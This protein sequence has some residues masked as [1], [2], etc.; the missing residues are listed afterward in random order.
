MPEQDIAKGAASGDSRSD[1]RITRVE[2]LGREARLL[3][4]ER[5][6]GGE[7]G[8]AGGQYVIINTGVTLPGGKLAKRAYS[9]L[10]SDAV[11]RRGEIAVKRIARGPGS[12]VLHEIAEGAELPFSGPW[13]KFRL[14]PGFSGRM[15]VIVTDT[16]ITAALGIVRSTAFAQDT[17]PAKVLW[18]VESPSYFVSESFVRGCIPPRCHATTVADFLPVG[19][20]ERPALACALV[21]AHLSAE[22]YDIVFCAGDG[23]VIY[24]LRDRLVSLGIPEDRVRLESFFNNP[25]K[26]SP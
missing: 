11:Q 7:L 18:L 8:F 3:E 15:L 17:N 9:L 19:H 6:D 21:E 2:S 14:E 24:P 13:G 5:R 12:G 10:S 22:T 1:L 26:K 25:L 4:I 20:P 16:A 23:A